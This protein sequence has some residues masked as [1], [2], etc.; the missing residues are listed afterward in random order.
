MTKSLKDVCIDPYNYEPKNLNEWKKLLNYY[1][2]SYTIVEK[3]H[4]IGVL[5][6]CESRTTIGTGNTEIDAIRSAFY[7]L[8]LD[9][10]A[11][12]LKILQ[13]ECDSICH[14]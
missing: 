11:G 2:L 4:G 13:K 3:L 1:G 6:K 5:L 12:W 9:H 7:S 8:N 14:L 10:H